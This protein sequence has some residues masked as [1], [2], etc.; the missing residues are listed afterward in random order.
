MNYKG[1]FDNIVSSCQ[2]TSK[3]SGM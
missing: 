1:L 2:N 3:L